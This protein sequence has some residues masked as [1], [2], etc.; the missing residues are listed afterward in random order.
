MIDT[1]SLLISQNLIDYCINPSDLTKLDQLDPKEC[2]QILPFLTRIWTRSSCFDQ[3]Q[4]SN[5]KLAIF[6][7]LRSYEDTNKICLY[8]NA[9][10]AQIY[11]D[12]IRHLSTR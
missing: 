4:Y 9:D 8:L 1:Q 12:V 6:S 2:R 5:F 3:L 10:F 11:E 7:K